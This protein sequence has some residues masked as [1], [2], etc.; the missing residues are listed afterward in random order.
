VLIG[1][2]PNPKIQNVQ[3]ALALI[4]KFTDDMDKEAVE[5]FEA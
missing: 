3:I 4:Y 2:V 1:K 5:K